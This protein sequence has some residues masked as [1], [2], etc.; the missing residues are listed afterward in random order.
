MF[1]WI[2]IHDETAKRLLD[3]KDRNH[4][5]VDI[6]A[7]MHEA[8]MKATKITDVGADGS[9]F[10]LKEIDPFTFFAN[11]NRT[12]RDDNRQAMWQFLKDEWKLESAVPQDFE[13]LPVANNQASW[14]IP[15]AK[16]RI[17]GHIPLLWKFYDHIMSVE[18]ES[19]D[20]ALLQEC[21]D[22]HH[23]GMTMLTMG[24]FWSCPKKWISTDSKN[25]EFAK[26]KGIPDKPKT[27][28]EYLTWL[29]TIREV[30][31]GDGVEFSRQ[32]H[33]WSLEKLPP[34]PPPAKPVPPIEPIPASQTDSYGMEDALA[35]LFMSRES[36]EHILEQLKRK[37]NIILQGAPGVG[38]TFIA[39]RL[40]WLQLGAK[41]ESAVEMVQFHQSYTY[42]DFVQGLR[43]TEDGHFAV[44][45]GCFYRLYRKA[46]ANPQ[47]DYFLVIDE[48]NRGNLSK[49]LGELMILIETDKRSEKL[50]LAY[51]EEP[52]TVP[53][54]LYLVGTMNTADRS[55][56]LVDYA[57]RRRFA[58]LAL[59]PGFETD[60]F[61]AHLGRHGIT[62][63]QIHH[64]RNQ[65]AALNHEIAKDETNLGG[66]YR[67]GHSFF[68]PVVSIPDFAKWFRSI[69]HY[70]IM[71]LLEE[72]WMDDPKMV[73]QF[74]LTLTE[75]IP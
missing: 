3:F 68:T 41:N 36:L 43:P 12:V 1:T 66:G 62:S 4:E 56:S 30:I 5:L 51:S 55:L 27:A 45:N 63:A 13:G 48:I 33:L 35:E 10:Q 25:I 23:V 28:V 73:Q 18:P 46:L 59:D 8:G 32:A 26:T 47:Q 20:P 65:M 71:P 15:Y 19:L 42:E 2:P 60:A 7:R 39:K 16:F 49:I 21:L 67:I 54:N 64:I 14:L 17:P 53:P 29:P 22:L 58:F 37:K 75:S 9:Q 34:P 72:Y 61:S 11:F 70:E 74:R 57:L 44:K 6:L 40:A 24:M 38:K 31:G 50:T 69:V 52:F